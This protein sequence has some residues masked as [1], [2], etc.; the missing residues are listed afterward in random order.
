MRHDVSCALCFAAGALLIAACQDQRDP[1]GPDQ[2]PAPQGSI[3]QVQ[4][5]AAV[6]RGVSPQVMALP[7]TVLAD[8][9]EASGLLVFGVEHAGVMGSV[10]ALL[11][12]LGVPASAYRIEVTQPVGLVVDLQ[13]EHRPTVD[14]IQLSFK[15]FVCTLGFNVPIPMPALRQP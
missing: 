8:D 10:R 2:T 6:F 12:R 13:D 5:R 4:Q 7:G 1:I 3:Q 14:G 9:D 15:A 11:T